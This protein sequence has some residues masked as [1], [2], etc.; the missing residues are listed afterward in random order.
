[1]QRINKQPC[2]TCPFAGDEPLDITEGARQEIVSYV[3]A[4]TNHLCHSDES[5]QT[6]CRGGRDIYLRV[7]T[8]IGAIK[9]PTDEA[10]AEAMKEAGLIPGLHINNC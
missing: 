10:L 7:A 4:G 6:V 8:M 1:M 3:I 2:R 5:N 9:A